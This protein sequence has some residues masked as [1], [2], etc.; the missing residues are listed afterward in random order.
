MR[1]H[2]SKQRR[3]KHMLKLKRRQSGRLQNMQRLKQELRQKLQNEHA[4]K[5]KYVRRPK[6]IR[7]IDRLL[8]R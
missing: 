3:L 6:Q 7:P 2:N 8:K 1:G 4:L 5:R